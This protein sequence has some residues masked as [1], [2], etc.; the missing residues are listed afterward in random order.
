MSEQEN[1]KIARQYT[2]NLNKRNNDA[3]RTLLA[4]D[5][6]TEAPGERQ[7]MNRDQTIQFNQRFIDAFPNLHFDMKEIIAQGD[8]VVISWVATGTHNNPLVMSN[9]GS[10]P[11][12]HRKVTVPG[13]TVAEIRNNKITHQTL[14]WDQVTF[15]M[16]LGVMTEQDM[17]TM[18]RR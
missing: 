13:V 5:T 4:D 6:H 17:M 18:A 12:S 15:L 3:N 16:Q 11:P 1:V 14:T 7:P 10:L 9:G 2:E 8:H